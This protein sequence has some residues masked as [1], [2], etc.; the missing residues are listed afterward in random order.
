MRIYVFESK[1]WVSVQYYAPIEVFSEWGIDDIG[2]ELNQ[3]FESMLR[4]L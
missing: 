1:D 2:R 4:D 3:V